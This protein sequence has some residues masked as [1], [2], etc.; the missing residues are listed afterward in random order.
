LVR[1]SGLTS[2]FRIVAREPRERALAY[3]GL[4][5]VLVSPRAHGDNLPLKIGDYM[6]A[7]KPI[8]AT[9]IPAHTVVLDSTRA[10]LTG[11]D[12]ESI[13]RGILSVLEDGTEAMRLAEAAKLYGDTYLSWSSF[14]ESMRG[15]V[16]QLVR[17][18]QRAA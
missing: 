6:A 11:T 15:Y 14:F 10:V 13:A 2:H 9:R 18:P 8:V 17:E 3:I 5:D 4:A 1:S 16:Q 7:T 12:Q